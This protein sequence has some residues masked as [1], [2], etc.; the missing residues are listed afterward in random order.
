MVGVRHVFVCSC[1]GMCNI[2]QPYIL[3]II[4]PA[5]D[6]IIQRRLAPLSGFFYPWKCL[7]NHLNTFG[8]SSGWLSDLINRDRRL[9]RHP[10]SGPFRR[11]FAPWPVDR[12][13]NWPDLACVSFCQCQKHN[14]HVIPM[15]CMT[16]T[17]QMK[18][19]GWR[20]CGKIINSWL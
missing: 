17:T 18:F 2:V 12:P 6:H 14:T 9:G 1:H 20:W 3:G 19:L 8:I 15:Q 7:R 13:A 5:Q 16:T 11:I 10:I 4:I